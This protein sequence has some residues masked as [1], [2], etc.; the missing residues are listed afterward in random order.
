[1]SSGRMHADELDTDASLVR[2]LLEA[3]FP[4]WAGLPVEPVRSAGTDN[5]IYRLGDGMAVR[6]PRIPAAAAQVDKEQLW[7]PRLAPLLP[8]PVPV[9]LAKGAPGEGYPWHWSVCRWLEGEN[10]TLE[11]LAEAA[12]AAADLAHF[13]AALQRIDATG[14]PPPGPHNSGRGV[15]LAV[16]DGPTRAAIASL[17]GMLDAGAVTAAWEAALQ[18]PPHDGPP[19]WI[20]GDLQPG[21]LL[22]VGGRLSAVIDFGCLGVGDP[23]CD[24]QAAWNLFTAE[25]REAFRSALG[26]DGATWAR[27]RGWA[28]SVALIALPY[29]QHTNPFL[30]GVARHTIREV[31]ADHGHG[32]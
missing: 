8:L 5:A 6:L 22:A 29:Y 10:A 9:P 25:A 1:M 4:Q 27:G 24:L 12:Q 16:R 32:A 2:R 3:Q 14:G 13:V 23:A 20:H 17:Q 28:L 19:V 30:A 11:R 15:P 7:L 31:L 21:N 26:V 18:A